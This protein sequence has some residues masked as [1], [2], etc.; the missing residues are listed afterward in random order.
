M[1]TAPGYTCIRSR[2]ATTLVA[3]LEQSNI[4]SL[5]ASP[6]SVGFFFARG[7]VDT[8][9][10]SDYLTLPNRFSQSGGVSLGFLCG[11]ICWHKLCVTTGRLNLRPNP[12][13]PSVAIQREVY[14]GKTYRC[15][16]N[17]WI[18]S[19]HPGGRRCYL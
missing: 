7:R 9:I 6:A 2:V 18:P 13:A 3:W 10:A 11:H 1:S 8:R 12:L 15:A 19:D 14:R 17:D 4:S 5:E 16:W